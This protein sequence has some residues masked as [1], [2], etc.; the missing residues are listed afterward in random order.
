[1][2]ISVKINKGQPIPLMWYLF[3]LSFFFRILAILALENI[4]KILATG[5]R[6]SLTC[7]K[8][9]W[10]TF[11]DV[12]IFTLTQRELSG[13]SLICFLKLIRIWPKALWCIFLS[14]LYFYIIFFNLKRRCWSDLLVK[15]NVH[16][17][18][19]VT[20]SYIGNWS[21][22]VRVLTDGSWFYFRKMYRLDPDKNRACARRT[23]SVRRFF[24]AP[25]ANVKTMDKIFTILCWIFSLLSRPRNRM[26]ILGILARV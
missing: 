21:D 13:S 5:P 26:E 3:I 24:W 2:T 9:F 8:L 4:A 19:P 7:S 25:K 12:V 10:H 16:Y 17:L 20:Y 18:G 22:P 23:V 15:L 1:M 11:Y 14:E 6:L